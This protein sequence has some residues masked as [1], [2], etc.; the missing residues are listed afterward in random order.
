MGRLPDNVRH[1]AN[2]SLRR[3]DYEGLEDS[4]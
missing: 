2:S 3:A 1:I 4:R